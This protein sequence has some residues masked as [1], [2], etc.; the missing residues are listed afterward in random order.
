M[1][2]ILWIQESRKAKLPSH[3]ADGE[4]V[5]ARILSRRAEFR[6]TE[7]EVVRYSS[8][9]RGTRPQVAIRAI[10]VQRSTIEVA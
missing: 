3:A 8:I 6:R 5:V 4:P 2:V 9:L 1:A 7:L 10:I